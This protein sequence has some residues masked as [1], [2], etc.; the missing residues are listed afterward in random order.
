MKALKKNGFEGLKIAPGEQ[1]SMAQAAFNPEKYRVGM[2]IQQALAAGRD[3]N[4]D[5][6]LTGVFGLL[7]GPISGG[8]DIKMVLTMR[9]LDPQ[10]GKVLWGGTLSEKGDISIFHPIDSQ[11]KQL[12]SMA[13]RMLAEVP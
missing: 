13:A 9:L 5:A 12:Q 3:V 8:H 6:V 2:S 1:M 4:A 7:F 11:A 10:T